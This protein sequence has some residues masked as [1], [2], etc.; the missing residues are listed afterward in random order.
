MASPT[1]SPTPAPGTAAAAFDKASAVYER[2]TGGCT[3][4]AAKFLLTLGPKVDSSSVILD[5]ACGTG[6]VTEEIL[7]QFSNGAK[8]KI[9]AADFAP[10]MVANFEAKAKSQG[11][12][13]DGD[14][15][16]AL[17]VSVMDAENLTYPDGTFTHSY[18]NLGFPFFPDG[19]KAAGHVY[20]T[21]RPGGTAFISTWK[22]LGYRRVLHAAQR[23][24]RPASTLWEPPMPKDW[25]TQE[26]L[27]RVLESAGFEAE[28]IRIITKPV[29]YRGKDLEDL[30]DILKTS[31]LGMV[32]S[33]WS[34]EEKDQWIKELS[35]ALT[36]QEQ[37]SASL[38]MIAWIAVAQK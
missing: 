23:A 8:L 1:T 22:M 33:G 30:L 27:V 25:Y 18:T 14:G 24:V 17:T 38:E 4:E 2:M 15:D 5:N 16:N 34:E 29:G 31:F 9:F 37:E 13:V 6:I 26:K 3:R 21:L 12:I 7:E 19:E 10:S 28:K 11:W 20:R 32:T 36:E 35:N